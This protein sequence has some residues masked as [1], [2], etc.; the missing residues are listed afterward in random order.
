MV[1]AVT[2]LLLVVRWQEVCSRVCARLKSFTSWWSLTDDLLHES[3]REL[4][5]TAD[6]IRGL[7]A[8]HL[9]W[10]CMVRLV[11]GA[12]CLGTDEACKLICSCEESIHS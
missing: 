5:R 6:W 8:L 7:P 9:I 10:A 1:Y 12:V 2:D 3:V 4:T 11:V